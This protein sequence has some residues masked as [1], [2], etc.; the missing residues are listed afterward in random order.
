MNQLDLAVGSLLFDRSGRQ[1]TIILVVSFFGDIANV[2]RLGARFDIWRKACA[3]V[4]SQRERIDEN[5]RDKRTCDGRK[6]IWSAPGHSWVV[7][8]LDFTTF[9]VS[10]ETQLVTQL[11]KVAVQLSS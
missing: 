8:R 4:T 5:E 10:G 11:I 9:T 6:R 7:H 1:F 2:N 3:C